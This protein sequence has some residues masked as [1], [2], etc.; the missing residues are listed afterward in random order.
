VP[1]PCRRRVTCKQHVFTS[2]LPC[3]QAVFR[4]SIAARSHLHCLGY[5]TYNFSLSDVIQPTRSKCCLVIVIRVDPDSV[6]TTMS[7]SPSAKAAVETHTISTVSGGICYSAPTVSNVQVEFGSRCW[8][9]ARCLRRLEQFR[10]KH[11]DGRVLPVRGMN[12]ILH[13]YILLTA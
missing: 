6:A 8:L 3:D 4:R 9:Y 1:S 10:L 12:R 11:P 2:G 5:S 13:A 7:S